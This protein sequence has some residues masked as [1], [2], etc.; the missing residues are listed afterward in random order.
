MSRTPSVTNARSGRLPAVRWLALLGL[1]LALLPAASAGAQSG[2][3]ATITIT[4][5][6]EDGTAL[7]FA[8]FQ[9]I[10]STG[11][12]LT[13]RETEPPGGTVSIAIELT[14]PDLT[15][16]V[17]MET[18]PA[19]AVMPP[20][21]EVGPFD[22]GD[23]VDLTFTTSFEDDCVL[24]S[25]SLYQYTCPD[26][27]DASVDDY[28]YFRD[29]C[30]Q[31]DNGVEFTLA[32]ADGGQSFPLTTGAYGID[33]R[34]PIVGLLPGDYT[35]NLDSGDP[36]ETLA[37]CL[38]FDGTPLEA[39]EP[40]DISRFSFDGDEIAFELD[41][42][43]RV[44]CD[45]FA[46]GE[47]V[48][49]D[50]GDSGDEVVVDDEPV[51]ESDDDAVEGAGGSA[52]IEFH[53]ATCP[54]GYDGGDYF[55]DCRD[56]GTEGVE[57]TVT[58]LDTA[59]TDSE[60]STVPVSPGFGI[61]V[62]GGL[63][64]DTYVMEEDVPGDF[65]SL[66]VYC[67]DQP[68]G[69]PRI[70]T[71]EEG[72]QQYGIELAAGQ[73]V[74]CDWFII[75]DQQF[76]PAILRLTKFTCEPGY[77]GSTYAEFTAE[78]TEPTAGV[79]FNL[80]N[81][82]GYYVDDDTNDEGKIRY[83]DLPP[84]DNYLLTEDLPGD[85][86]QYRVAFCATNGGDY[87]EYEAIDGGEIDLDPIG[88]GDQIQCL[89]YNVP[90]DQNVGNGSVEIH[91]AECPAGT[92]G[93]YYARCHDDVVGGIGFEL[94]GPG[95]VND[96]GNT[97]ANGEL[98]FSELPSGDYVISEIAPVDYNVA[99]YAVFCTRDGVAFPTEYDD[100]TGLRITFELPADADIIC[101]WYNIPRGP[102]PTPTPDPAD[103]EGGTITVVKYACEDDAEDIRNFSEECEVAGEGFEFELTAN[104]GGR[105]WT[106]ET[107]S[108][109]KL[110]FTGLA[111]GAYD[112][113]EVDGTWCKAESDR[114]DADGNL[115]V[116]NE[117][118]TNVYIY[119]CGV[120]NVTVLPATGTGS[121]GPSFPLVGWLAAALAAIVTI[122]AVAAK[123][124]AAR[125]RA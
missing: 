119:N 18:P 100:D 103:A 43:A 107:R 72:P 95:S 74:I 49:E 13:T 7:P 82:G 48:S 93:D 29:N 102:A 92:T 109:G 34:A 120:D 47:A 62:I 42:R 59:Y 56:N 55:N 86:L 98:T 101:D 108:D 83:T 65:V 21:Q 112:L 75:P 51:E 15:Y 106:G 54:A 71:P 123:P 68:G 28:A 122:G 17:T 121:T 3:V 45:F 39:P 104:A 89:W 53:V 125:R 63:P 57:F 60:T 91:K 20:D 5:L 6:T 32:E 37:Y 61:A 33:G 26:G 88:D 27:L 64:A 80:S 46:V 24:G 4:S 90:V 50:D 113:D 30:V 23:S 117:G 70:P 81:G 19:C 84:G 36:D 38:T 31:A 114:V 41:S 2:G 16:T 94:D 12:L 8:R 40:S 97:D 1:L 77:G 105:S 76:E 67:A 11:E 96:L 78:C 87:I 111:D 115:L 22:D 9:V 85:A 35:A 118:N 66:W 110:V 58:G 44:A 79:F 116:Q 69:G 10:D 52:S 124:A 73:A 99:V 14:D 25:V